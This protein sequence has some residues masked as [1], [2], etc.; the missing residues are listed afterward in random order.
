MSRLHRLICLF[1]V[2]LFVI[3]PVAPAVE[4][5]ADKR[6]AV[7]NAEDKATPLWNKE[8]LRAPLVTIGARVDE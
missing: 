5:W 8:T 3:A 4:T 1:A 7:T 6:L 2:C